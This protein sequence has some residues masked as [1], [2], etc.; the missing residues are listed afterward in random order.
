MKKEQLDV[1]IGG[2]KGHGAVAQGVIQR[3]LTN[4]MNIGGLRPWI[5]DDENNYITSNDGNALLIGN[6]ATLRKDEWKHYDDVILKVT[7]ERLRGVADLYAAGLTYTIPNGMGS[8]VLEYEDMSDMEAAQLSMD[9]A[10]RGD[11]DRPEFDISYLPL[12]ITHKDFMINARV[13]A[14]SRTTGSPLDTTMAEMAARKVAEKLEDMLFNGASTYAYGGGTIYGYTDFPSKNTYSL[15][16]NWD[17]LDS[18]SIDGEGILSDVIGM[19]AAS[20][21]AGFYGPWVLYIPTNFETAMDKDFKVNSDKSI[22]QRV[23]EI[24]GLT[25]IRVADKLTADNVILVQMTSDVVRMVNGMAVTPVEWNTEG[26]MILHYKVMTIQV[27]Q[28]RATQEGDCGIVH[29]S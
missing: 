21:A 7:E 17:E 12:P 26:G 4:G 13:L 1:L 8:T 28:L 10:T 22:R 20:I 14:A 23:L 24:D 6:A 11:K 19:K 16:A 25:D 29:G 27:P 15:T 2:G 9:G 18:S 3:L 5:G